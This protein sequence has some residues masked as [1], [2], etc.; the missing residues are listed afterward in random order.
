METL[1]GI[2]AALVLNVMLEAGFARNEYLDDIDGELDEMDAAHLLEV[3]AK[4]KLRLRSMQVHDIGGVHLRVTQTYR[5]F[6]LGG[7]TTSELV[8][9]PLPKTIFILFLKH[10]EGIEFKE[11]TLYREELLDIYSKVSPRLDSEGLE[12][13]VDLLL[14]RRSNSFREHQTRLSR[15]LDLCLGPETAG[16][17]KISGERGG[18]KSISLDRALVHWD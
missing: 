8:L 3:V 2:E 4:A 12:R 17:C 9:R 13:S 11:L 5:I 10:P 1:L 15:A 14:S 16:V 18:L 7:T 6:I